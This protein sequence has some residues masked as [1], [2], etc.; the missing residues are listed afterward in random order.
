[1]QQNGA[2]SAYGG[3]VSTVDITL[4]LTRKPNTVGYLAVDSMDI[5]FDYS[6]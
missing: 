1:L 4:S 2:T 6:K 3:G 5:I